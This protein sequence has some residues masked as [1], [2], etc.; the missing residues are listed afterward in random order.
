MTPNKYQKEAMRTAS[1]M[2][3]STM[4]PLVNAALGIAGE[5]DI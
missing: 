2:D 1:G 3:Y 4:E 5:G